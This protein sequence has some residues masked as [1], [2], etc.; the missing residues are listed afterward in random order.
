MQIVGGFMTKTPARQLMLWGDVED[1]IKAERLLRIRR[2]ERLSTICALM[3]LSGA[4]WLAWPTLKDAF[5]GNA[6][7]LSGL[8]MPILVI[9]W[10]IVLQDLILDDPKARTRVGAA[11]SIFWP[12]LVMFSIRSYGTEVSDILAAVL[13]LGL[14]FSMY[15]G[16]AKTL[17]GGID[18]MR[19]P[20]VVF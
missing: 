18:V 17:R 7:L 3:C 2:I 14:G 8:G 5:S 20:L 13:L 15:Q 12:F 19:F 10:G 9:L 11:C 1:A 6:E 16:S 4:V